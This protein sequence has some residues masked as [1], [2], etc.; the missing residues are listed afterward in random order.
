MASTLTETSRVA[1][2]DGTQLVFTHA[3]E[4]TKC[5]M[6]FA[7]YLPPQASGGRRAHGGD[8]YSVL[9]PP[10]AQAAAETPVP[11]LYFLSG[12]TCTHE[13]FVTKAGGQRL[14]AEH[15]IAVVCPDTSPRGV[16]VEGDDAGWDFGTGAGFYL[17]ATEPGWR[18]HYKMYEYVTAELPALVE[19]VRGRRARCCAVLGQRRAAE[20][21]RHPRG[22]GHHR[23]QHG[24]PRRPHL[25]AEEPRHVQERLSLCAHLPPL[26]VPVG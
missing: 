22:Q 25:R 21:P 13:N 14:A 16:P 23:A 26:G 20:F 5:T 9:T 12:L 7:V 3:S 17:N 6:T 10:A 15:G 4:A 18:D 11:A 19:A 1:S 24:R 8:G 2:F